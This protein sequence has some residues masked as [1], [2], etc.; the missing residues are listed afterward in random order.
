MKFASLRPIHIYTIGEK[1]VIANYRPISLLII[2]PKKFEKV[3]YNRIRQHIHTNNL[4][5]PAQ[6]GFM[7]N[8]SMKTAIYSLTNHILETLEHCNHSL[9]IFCDLTKAF[10]CVVHDILLSKLTIYGIGG[11]T[12]I[13][14]KSYL[15][16]I[17]QRVEL[18][19]NEH[20][21]YCS[22]W[23]TVKYWVPQGLIVGPLLFLLYIIDLLAAL[24]TEN[25]LLLYANDTSILVS[26]TNIGR[27]QV[28]SKLVLNSLSN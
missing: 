16:N 24:I 19:N 15:E 14:L 18:Y 17:R 12:V 2:F 5:S 7:E 8:R 3:M 6:F 23:E 25:K 27:I 1:A 11:I 28:R 20:G 10:D 21:K 13:W 26:G 4:F 22:G 9:G